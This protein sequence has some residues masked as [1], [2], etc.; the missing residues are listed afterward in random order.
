MPSLREDFVQLAY[1]A[2]S[3]PQ[4]HLVVLGTREALAQLLPS[5]QSGVAQ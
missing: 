1:V 3:R 4:H 5:Q 2:F